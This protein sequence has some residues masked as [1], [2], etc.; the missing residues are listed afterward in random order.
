MATFWTF[1]TCNYAISF[2]KSIFKV[3]VVFSRIFAMSVAY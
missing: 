2:Q 1:T 3:V